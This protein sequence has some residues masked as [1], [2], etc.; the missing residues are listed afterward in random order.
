M[1]TD[2]EPVRQARVAGESA[3]SVLKD[4]IATFYVSGA[5]MPITG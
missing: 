1:M 2:P 5:S 4:G 3:A